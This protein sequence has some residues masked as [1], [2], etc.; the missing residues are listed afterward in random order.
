VEDSAAAGLDGESRGCYKQL[1]AAAAAAAA[2]VA[3]VLSWARS[4]ST[5]FFL[6][7]VGHEQGC[8]IV[9]FNGLNYQ[10]NA[11]K[12]Q[13]KYLGVVCQTERG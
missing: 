2:L 6:R 13:S 3:H 11:D 10:G 9:N 5:F 12:N 4:S 1:P 7:I 8:Q